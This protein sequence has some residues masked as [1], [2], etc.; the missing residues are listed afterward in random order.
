MRKEEAKAKIE[1]E[2]KE[3]KEQQEKPITD[4]RREGERQ[5]RKQ[6][7]SNGS[8]APFSGCTL[9]LRRIHCT[10]TS[11]PAAACGMRLVDAAHDSEVM[12]QCAIT[13]FGFLDLEGRLA[14]WWFKC[15]GK[16]HA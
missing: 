1:E 7:R 2:K 10:C 9:F 4:E 15:S 5:N 11:P 16:V 12:I 6:R 13:F 14:G 8:V 3:R